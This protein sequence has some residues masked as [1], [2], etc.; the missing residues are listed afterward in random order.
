MTYK[1]LCNITE[2]KLSVITTSL[3]HGRFLRE[4]IE[5]VANQSYRNFEHIIIDG[6][7]T[8]QTLDILAEYPH[9]RWLSEADGS[10]LEALNKGFAIAKGQ[11][12]VQCCVSDGFLD[13]NWFQKC[14]EVLDRDVET[15]LVW[16]LPQDLSEGGDLLGVTYSEFFTDP[17][18]QKQEFL[19]LWL[20]SGFVLPEGNY[21]V[22]SDII[23]RYFPN[24]Q[25][26]EHFQ[27]QYHLG[28]IY[29]FFVQGYCP[30]FLLMVANFGRAHHD[31]RSL[32]RFDI[33]KPAA[34]MY[35]KSVKDYRKKLFSGMAR[36]YFRNARSE[37]I[38]ELGPKDLWQ[39][40]IKMWRNKI[41]RSRLLRIDLYTL[42]LKIRIRIKGN[43][44]VR[45]QIRP[46][47]LG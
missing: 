18:P 42:L 44:N 35:I 7:S 13:M 39:L 15:S 4:T 38:G 5:S 29:K 24:E 43:R 33:E 26:E 12:I 6:G 3:N 25:S 30:F 2:P 37:V 40:R 9:I 31:Q 20:A 8:D 22:R 47:D 27:I 19:A 36:H 32:R 41:L 16:G 17:P 28:F 21:C 1:D 45:G 10:P 23:R 34:D 46:E 14:V 11:Y